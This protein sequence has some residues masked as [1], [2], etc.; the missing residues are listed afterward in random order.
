MDDAGAAAGAASTLADPRALSPAGLL[1]AGD[2]VSREAPQCSH[3][4]GQPRLARHIFYR[5]PS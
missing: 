5:V 1:P 3:P 2:G 4:G